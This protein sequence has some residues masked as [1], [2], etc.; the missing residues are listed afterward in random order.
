MRTKILCL[1]A[2]ALLATASASGQEY[3]SK[4]VN[5]IVPAAPG[6]AVDTNARVVA[7][8]LQKLWGQP[9]VVQYKPGA[10]TLIGT[11]FVA[12]APADGY[13]LLMTSSSF[14]V[15]PN[16]VARMPYTEAELIP[17]TLVSQ[18][19]MALFVSPV[20]PV[21]NVAELI[22]YAKASPGKLSFGAPDANGE[23]VGYLFNQLA[24]TNIPYVAYK[25]FGPMTTDLMGGHLPVGISGAS[26]IRALAQAGKVKVLGVASKRTFAGL[27]DAP[28]LA[29]DTLR[30]FEA[31]VWFG[32]LAPAGTPAPLVAKLHADIAKVLADPATRRRLSE[33]GLEVGTS[34]QAEFAGLVR[35]EITKSKLIASTAGVKPE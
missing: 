34:S 27:P 22:Q 13:T 33:T 17:V 21:N 20:L 30:G 12:K 35:S 29:K 14:T 26:T 7:D 25:G 18:T 24:G 32:L 11:G 2:F 6:G 5:L 8:G 3:P 19:P 1:A 9:V 10:N 28:L 31:N 4:P 16:L 23:F 15:L